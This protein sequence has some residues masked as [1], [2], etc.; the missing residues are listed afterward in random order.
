MSTWWKL[1]DALGGAVVQQTDANHDFVWV[2][3]PGLTD[4][5]R[6]CKQDLTEAK[7]PC[8]PEPRPGVTLL[9]RTGRAWQR[10]GGTAFTPQVARDFAEALFYASGA[11]DS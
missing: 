7:E 10:F 5:V 8:P 3:V 1:P 11:S 4:L 2:D 9:D 6:L